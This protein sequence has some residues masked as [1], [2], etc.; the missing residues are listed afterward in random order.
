M[1]SS[2]Y[3]EA[4]TANQIRSFSLE[5]DLAGLGGIWQEILL[6]RIALILTCIL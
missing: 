4:V 5:R 3:Y 2:L 6:I 1:I